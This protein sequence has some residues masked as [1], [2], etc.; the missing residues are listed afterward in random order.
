MADPDYAA[1]F[2]S[3]QSSVVQLETLEINHPGFSRQY[4]IVR[5]AMQ[6]LSATLEDGTLGVFEF[7]PCRIQNL[8][9]R[10]TL[11]YGIRVDL[12]DL[13]EIIP[14]ELDNIALGVNRLGYDSEETLLG[15]L[16]RLAD[17]VNVQLP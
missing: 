14:K 8:G 2:L 4:R 16:S 1:F 10:D 17:L 7:Y 15:V 6:G 13:G 9:A 5:N 12:G 3:T 11:D